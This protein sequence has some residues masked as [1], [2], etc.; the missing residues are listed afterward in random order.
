MTTALLVESRHEDS[1]QVIER[2]PVDGS[3]KYA[4]SGTTSVIGS[5]RTAIKLVRHGIKTRLAK[6]NSNVYRRSKGDDSSFQLLHAKSLSRLN[7]IEL[8]ASSMRSMNQNR[9]R[10]TPQ[11][12]RPW[13][14]L[15]WSAGGAR[16]E[17]NP[18]ESGAF[19]SKGRE[20]RSRVKLFLKFCFALTGRARTIGA[21]VMGVL[22]LLG[23][24][25]AAGWGLVVIYGGSGSHSCRPAAAHRGG[26]NVGVLG[27]SVGLCRCSFLREK[28]LQRRNDR[29]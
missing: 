24:R 4:V 20:I 22:L 14:F 8:T 13:E 19:A 29:S 10:L 27:G 16:A 12:L 1:W 6:N 9:N 25:R 3:K 23:V 17:E 5:C 11:C 15:R 21:V 2:G 28:R 18:H 26:V 7:W